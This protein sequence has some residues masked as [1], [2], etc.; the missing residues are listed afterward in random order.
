MERSEQ[1]ETIIRDNSK[2]FEANA[3][4]YSVAWC[5][6]M[7]SVTVKAANKIA[8]AAATAAVHGH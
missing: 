4:K 8:V 6:M 3:C 5:G 1:T 7:M 2:I